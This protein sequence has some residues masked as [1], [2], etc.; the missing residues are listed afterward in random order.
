MAAKMSGPIE[1]IAP[2]YPCWAFL[3]DASAR[4]SLGVS[5]CRHPSSKAAE[6]TGSGAI[7]KKAGIPSATAAADSARYSTP[8]TTKAAGMTSVTAEGLSL[9]YTS[10]QQPQKR[11]YPMPVN[12]D[13][14]TM[15]SS[16]AVRL[17]T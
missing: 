10:A 7:I 11:P 2:R 13:P 6:M 15:K 14:A 9:P 17:C 16:M 3:R 1:N 12:R 8:A 4:T 5:L